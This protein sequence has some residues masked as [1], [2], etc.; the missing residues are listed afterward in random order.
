MNWRSSLSKRF[1]VLIISACPGVL[2]KLYCSEGSLF[3]PHESE[4][5][6]SGEKRKWET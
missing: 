1:I 3:F 4:F 5:P 2:A 6:H